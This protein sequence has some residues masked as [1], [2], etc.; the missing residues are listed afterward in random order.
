MLNRRLLNALFV[1]LLLTQNASAQK[2]T[3]E[4]KVR[5]DKA[6][7]E[8]AGF[9]IYN[10]LPKA[11]ALARETGKPIEYSTPEQYPALKEKYTSQLNYSGDIVESCIHCHQIG[12]AR[13]EVHWSQGQPIPEE[14]LYPYPHPKSNE[15]Y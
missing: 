5:A 8:S 11:Y 3:R 4:E 15:R 13:R 10:D 12:E 1:L 7:V 2:P 14:L 6:K 9:W